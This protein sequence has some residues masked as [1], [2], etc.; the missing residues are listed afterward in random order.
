MKICLFSQCLYTLGGVQRAVTEIINR[1]ADQGTDITV[2]MPGVSRKDGCFAVDRRIRIVD[3]DEVFCARL[4]GIYKLLHMLNRRTAILDNRLGTLYSRGH[5]VKAAE[6]DRLVN[7]INS[8]KFDVVIG[9]ADKYSMILS[10]IADRISARTVGWMHSTFQAY[11]ET[12]GQNS[13][14]LKR[15]NTESLKRLDMI[16]VLNSSDR[17]RVEREIGSRCM[18]LHSPV[19]CGAESAA[20]EKE[21]EFLFTGRLN[22]IVKGLDYLVDI[23]G[24]VVEKRPDCRLIIVGAGQDE[25]YLR[26]AVKRNGLE[27]NVILAGYRKNVEDY[28]RA[29]RVLVSTSRWEGFG[30]TITEAMAQGVPCVAFENEGSSEIIEDGISGRLIPKFDTQRFADALIECIEDREKYVRLSEGALRRVKQFDIERI[31]RQFASS[32][33]SLM[34]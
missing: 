30:L 16:F 11:Y 4:G 5:Y 29:S 22:R 10:M 17:A 13:Y 3:I 25:D 15:L 18:I 1:V 19:N 8:E 12:R 23:M 2:V 33:E 28:Y 26:K 21:Y 7:W 32:I 31:V 6:L 20:C 14:G 27:R 34:G 9:V 24:R